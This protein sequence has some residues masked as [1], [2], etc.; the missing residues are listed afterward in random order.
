MSQRLPTRHAR[1]ITNHLGQHPPPGTLT[2]RIS[3]AKIFVSENVI[4]RKKKKKKE[5]RKKNMTGF[6]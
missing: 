4:Q 2:L 1:I 6:L 3:S 5:K